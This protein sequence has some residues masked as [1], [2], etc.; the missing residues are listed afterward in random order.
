MGVASD[1]EVIDF[2]LAD[3]SVNAFINQLLWRRY[4]NAKGFNRSNG[5]DDGKEDKKGDQGH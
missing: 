5:G 1:V 3:H 2:W 4:D